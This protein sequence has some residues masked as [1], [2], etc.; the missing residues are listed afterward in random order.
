MHAQKA[1]KGG[2]VPLSDEEIDRMIK[3]REQARS[4]L[5]YKTA[6]KIRETLEKNGVH[7]H[8]GVV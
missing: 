6:D 8:R 4:T 3:V 2:A 5:D 7:V 1:A